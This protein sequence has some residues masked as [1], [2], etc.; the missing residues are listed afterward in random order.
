MKSETE[1]IFVQPR[2][3]IILRSIEENEESMLKGWWMK[4]QVDKTAQTKERRNVGRL[5]RRYSGQW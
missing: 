4:S 2:L 1:G 3:C 5:Q